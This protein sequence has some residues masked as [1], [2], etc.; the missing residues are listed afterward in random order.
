MKEVP[1]SAAFQIGHA[2]RRRSNNK[3]IAGVEL[4]LREVN[5]QTKNNCF[6]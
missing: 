2:F 6:K 5:T 4:R 1:G 3:M